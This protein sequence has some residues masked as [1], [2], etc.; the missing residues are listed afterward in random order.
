MALVHRLKLVEREVPH[1]LGNLF[2]FRRLSGDEWDE[3][4]AQSTEA[5]LEAAEIAQKLQKMI[6][7]LSAEEKAEIDA[8]QAAPTDAQRLNQNNANPRLLVKYGLVEW[9]GP[10][11]PADVPCNETEKADL[12]PK[13]RDWAAVQVLE[14]STI[15]EGEAIGS[16]ASSVNGATEPE[17]SA[18]VTSGSPL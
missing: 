2:A 1:E 13:T 18:L 12:D 3:A 16:V 15:A 10:N 7:G 6:E 11:Y 14:L 9:R 17:P 5:A 4:T 8:A